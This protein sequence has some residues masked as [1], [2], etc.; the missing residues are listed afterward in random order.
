M[1]CP[2]SRTLVRPILEYS[3]D[4]VRNRL[5]WNIDQWRGIQMRLKARIAVTELHS[6]RTVT[7]PWRL[8]LLTQCVRMSSLPKWLS[9]S[10]DNL[11]SKKYHWRRKGV[12]KYAAAHSPPLD[13]LYKKIKVKSNPLGCCSI[14][15]MRQFD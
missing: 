10:R 12:F 13:R 5:N 8:N 11:F 3:L 7:S 9:N 15:C 4:G 6:N 2:L 14:A 1:T